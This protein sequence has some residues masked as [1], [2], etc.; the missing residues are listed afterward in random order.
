MEPMRPRHFA[1]GSPASP[2]FWFT[3]E[4]QRGL[5]P[6]MKRATSLL[7]R[8]GVAGVAL[9]AV[10]AFGLTGA[11]ESR[12][13]ANPTSPTPTAPAPAIQ[14]GFGTIKGRLVWG[15]SEVPK[16]VLI[17]QNK[18]KDP[19]V[20]G[21][22]DL[23]KRDLVIDPQTKGIAFGFAYLPKPKGKNPEALKALVAAHPT[24]EI[25]QK[26]CEFL[27]VSVAGTKDQ[28]FVFK[29]SDP[30]GHNVHY[31]GFINNA[32]FALGPNGSA[33]RKLQPER[34][35]INLA[36]DIHPWMLGN[37]M[38]FDHPFF[39]V[40]GEDGSFEIKGVPAGTQN[41]IVWQRLAGYVTEG[42]SKGLAVEVKPGQVTDLGTIVLKP[43]QIR[44]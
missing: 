29:S 2:A 13:T 28:Q 43:E 12:A 7:A 34:R 39:A 10:M 16:P 23:Y 24:V 5:T 4:I 9:A 11:P 35:P 22:V 17:T 18:Q 38:V 27:P 14:K 3:P 15:G 33:T 26:N 6:K 25:D 19:Q 31:A 41:L 32:N 21:A 37:L 20:C 30:V 1:A 44:K 40:T 42:G 8:A 36:C